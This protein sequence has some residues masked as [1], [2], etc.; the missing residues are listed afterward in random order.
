MD[1]HKPGLRWLGAAVDEKAL[2]DASLRRLALRMRRE[3]CLDRWALKRWHY[4]MLRRFSRDQ[5]R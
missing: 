4:R 2:T 3:F 1:V 5:M